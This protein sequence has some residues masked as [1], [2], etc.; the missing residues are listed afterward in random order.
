MLF[1]IMLWSFMD[2][3]IREAIELEMHPHNMKRHDGL[4][5]GRSWNPFCSCLNKGDS[6]L[7]HNS[8]ITYILWFLFLIR[9]GDVSPIRTCLTTRLHL[10]PEPFSA[11]SSNRTCRHQL[12]IGAG[13]SW[14]KTLPVNWNWREASQ[15]FIFQ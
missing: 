15:N 1:Y 3:L 2:R 4:Y 14:F 6:H 5:L 11:S 12:P 8:Q 10:G 7:K 13:F 9:H